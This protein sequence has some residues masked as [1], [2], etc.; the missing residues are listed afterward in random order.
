MKAPAASVL[1]DDEVVAMLIDEP[2]LL[3]LADGLVATRQPAPEVSTPR[4]RFWRT[5]RLLTA[6]A[7]VT[8]CA[9]GALLLASPRQ[10]SPSLVDKALA[11]VG[12]GPVLHVVV[13][14]TAVFGGPVIDVET[15]K[16]LSRTLET[17]VWFDGGRDLKKTIFR[18][19]GEVLDEQLE[20]SQGGWTRG[21]PIYTCAWI[22]AHPAEATR[23]RVSCN[24]SGENGPTPRV[25]PEIPPTLE[26]ALAGFVD[27]YRSALAS[28]EAREAGRGRVEGRE[29]VWLEFR[30]NR[31]S[32]RV[33]VDAQTYVPLLIEQDGEPT[34]RV[35]TAESLPYD[36]SYFA[37]PPRTR[38]QTGGSVAS[39]REVTPAEAASVLGRRALWLGETWNG[40][41]LAE[42]ALEERTIGYG[43]DEEP[44]RVRV[45]RFTYVP[46]ASEQT[47]PSW[48][49]VDIFES[50]SCVLSV[51]WTCTPRDPMSTGTVGIVG[52]ISLVRSDDLY[53]SIWSPGRSHE[54]LEM[55]RAL[56]TV[57]NR[58]Q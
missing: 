21:G 53:I 34:Y 27:N 55:A 50:T 49:R 39:E 45:L 46:V 8:A 54:P 16:T 11:A 33:A 29:V 36:E 17:E 48:A 14:Q 40:L 22:A 51:G 41:R 56:T 28:G 58:S 57:A 9:V 47:A 10:G 5:R 42:V 32:E 19:D 38:T 7:V 2:Q 15:G 12:G 26:P 35:T 18:L 13:S 37:K 25:V 4:R 1:R 44:G 52:V 43:P 24:A 20:T 30:G 23:A 31:G 3:A 6:A